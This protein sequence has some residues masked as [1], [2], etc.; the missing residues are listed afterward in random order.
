MLTSLLSTVC[1]DVA[2]EPHLITLTNEV[3]QKKTA[4]K[5]EGA[6]L[7]IKAKHF[8]Q[9]GQTAFF[10][11]RVTHVNSTTQREKDTKTIFRT[12]EQEKKREYL[13]RILQVE[14][15][16]MT[17]L[18]FGTNGGLGE[19]CQRF[20]QHLAKKISA[21]DGEDYPQVINWIRTRLSFEIIRSSIAC[22]RGSRIPFRRN[23]EE[24]MN[25]FELKN[26]QGN[27]ITN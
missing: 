14:N 22:L 1:K 21:K 3:F 15:G 13:E 23:N 12:H 20:L 18:I 27:L 10:D 16:S 26:I 8:W 17:P 11:V 2:A 4:N 7:D 6:R 5:S 19:E 24:E 9:H 25:D